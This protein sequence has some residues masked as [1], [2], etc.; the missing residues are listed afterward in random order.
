VGEKI[1]IR[2]TDAGELSHP[3]HLHGQPFQVVAQDGFDLPQPV[4]MDAAAP[5]RGVAPT[6]DQASQ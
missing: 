3:F 6:A 2:I 5:G 1:R 4:T